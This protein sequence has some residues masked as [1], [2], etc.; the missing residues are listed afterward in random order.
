MRLHAL[1]LAGFTLL[2]VLPAGCRQ[3]RRVEAVATAQRPAEP[4][5]GRIAGT[6]RLQEGIP[7]P[8]I[9]RLEIVVRRRYDPDRT[10][11]VRALG[12]VQTWP[13]TFEVTVK[14]PNVPDEGQPVLWKGSP[15]DLSVFARGYV[16][17]RA[18]LVTESQ[19][20]TVEDSVKGRPL[21]LMLVPVTE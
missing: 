18:V 1:A 8:A 9:A 6:V 12:D 10:V 19:P 15:P 7:A 11:A 2:H 3:D 14:W 4:R 16:G 5:P 13:T 21:D 20:Y 17:D